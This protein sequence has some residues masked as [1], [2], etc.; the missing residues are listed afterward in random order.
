MKVET[1]L[2]FEGK[3]K[4]VEAIDF[5]LKVEF[6]KE[7]VYVEEWKREVVRQ[8]IARVEFREDKFQLTGESVDEIAWKL[9][10]VLLALLK[11]MEGEGA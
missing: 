4:I 2:C 1:D 10:R 7:L 11:T 8:F 6:F 9:G 3:S 5:P